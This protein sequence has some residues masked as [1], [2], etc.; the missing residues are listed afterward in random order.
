[1]SH[2]VTLRTFVILDNLQPQLAAFTG[3][4]GRG[5]PPVKEMASLWVEIAPG[6]AINTV[7]DVCLKKTSVQ[8]A[9]QVVE[10]A[11]GILEV[12]DFDQ[13][14]VRQAGRHMLESLGLTESDRMKPHVV[15]QQII[16]AVE[17]MHAQVVN[18]NR[19]GSLLI[20]G[21]SLFILECEPAA[22]AVYA[23]NEAEKAARIT[24]VHV[25]PY[26]AFGR[27]NLSGDEAQIDAA[28]AAAVTAL[29]SL[30]GRE[31]SGTR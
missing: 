20:P 4:T 22:Y 24:L 21:Q 30:S 18:R 10:R 14:E 8:P 27:L 29:Q 25:Q 7:T 9:V 31:V 3:C 28:A 2:G 5:F 19:D 26:G 12:H 15:S 1:M 17:P 23:A 11:F 13:G 16:R 6:I